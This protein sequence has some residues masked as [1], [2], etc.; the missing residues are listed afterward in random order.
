M[1]WITETDVFTF[2]TRPPPTELSLTKR[3]VLKNVATLFDPL[4]LLALHYQ[5]QDIITSHVD[6]W[7]GLGRRYWRRSDGAS[8][9]V[10]N[11]TRRFEKCIVVCNPGQAQ[12]KQQSTHS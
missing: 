10:V 2:S 12:L 7:I 8:A 11:R 9:A 6:S 5:S 3:N 4:G 1:V